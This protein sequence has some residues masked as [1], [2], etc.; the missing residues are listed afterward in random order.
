[1]DVAVDREV[2]MLY[3]SLAIPRG[4]AMLWSYGPQAP[5]IAVGSTGGGVDPFPKLGFEALVRDLRLARRFTDDISI[6]SLEGCVAQGHLEP[7]RELDWSAPVRPPRSA[8]ALVGLMR[9]GLRGVLRVSALAGRR[10][11]D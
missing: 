2:W 5:A 11:E 10:G 9:A 1:M 6:F 3:S 8:G 4:P 7:L